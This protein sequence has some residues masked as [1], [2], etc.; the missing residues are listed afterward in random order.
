MHE[1]V[2]PIFSTSAVPGELPGAVTQTFTLKASEA[3]TIVPFPGLA[4][5]PH[6]IKLGRGTP[7]G[8]GRY[9]TFLPVCTAQ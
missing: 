5:C 6:T 3:L 9:E 7:S 4:C 1:G 2:F 8:P